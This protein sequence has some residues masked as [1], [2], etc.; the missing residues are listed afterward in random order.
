MK[1]KELKERLAMP[2]SGE[3]FLTTG[4][5]VAYIKDG[6]EEINMIAETHVD[7][8]RINITKDKRFYHFPFDALKILEVRV[9]NHLNSKDEYRSVPRL[10]H[11][12][13]I[14]DADEV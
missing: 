6:L 2:E 13:I 5:I 14:K 9:K 8:Q 1:V 4:R 11:K 7:V 3:Q 12:P 10:I